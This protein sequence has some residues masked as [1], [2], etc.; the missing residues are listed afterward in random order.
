MSNDVEL[1]KWRQQWQAEP[2]TP[3]R[4]EEVERLR[5]RVLS[6]TRWQ[7][8]GLIAPFFVTFGVGGGTLLMAL[9][10]QQTVQIVIAIETWIFIAVCWI[11]SM[12]L[13][14]GTWRPLADTTAAFVEVSIRRRE[15]YI[16]GATFGMCLYVLQLVFVAVLLHFATNA[17]AIDVLTSPQMIVIGWIGLPSALA[18]GYWFRRRQRAELE[19]LLE[20]KR[21]LQGD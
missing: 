6:E 4:A 15:S 13:A 20:L 18:G 12:W 9:L 17:R 7:K 3:A 10:T 21:Q 5:R 19:R 1:Q 14:R 16:G 2:R 11:G 8:L